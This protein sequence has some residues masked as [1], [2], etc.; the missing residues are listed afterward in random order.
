MGNDRR[1]ELRKLAMQAK[2][3]MDNRTLHVNTEGAPI[4]KFQKGTDAVALYESVRDAILA[5]TEDCLTSELA[6]IGFTALLGAITRKLM[7]GVDRTDSSNIQPALRKFWRIL[8]W[9]RSY[10]RNAGS[11][12]FGSETDGRQHSINYSATARLDIV[13]TKTGEKTHAAYRDMDQTLCGHHAWK[14][15]EGATVPKDLKCLSCLD[16][17]EQMKACYRTAEHVQDGA[18]ADIGT[19]LYGFQRIEL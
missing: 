10:L 13:K 14:R 3:R 2:L 1:E 17:I 11:V 8:R 19:V 18:P 6:E 5:E 7:T 9:S 4:A 16:S 15:V 12:V